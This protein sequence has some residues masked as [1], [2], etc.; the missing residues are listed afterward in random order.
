MMAQAKKSCLYHL[1]YRS[2]NLY[3]EIRVHCE[4]REIYEI[5]YCEIRHSCTSFCSFRYHACSKTAL[6]ISKCFSD[7]I[8]F[9]E[10]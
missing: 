1:F 3:C 2:E 10:K 7:I 9:L 8:K 6:N 5:L 4:I